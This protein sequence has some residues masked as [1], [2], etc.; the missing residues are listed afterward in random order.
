[1]KFSLFIALMIVSTPALSADGV[2]A[3]SAMSADG[4]TVTATPASRSA[5]A[6]GKPNIP[7]CKMDEHSSVSINVN[8]TGSSIAEVKK[9]I[10]EQT[11]K[12][13]EYA[14]Q[15]KFKKFRLNN[16]NFNIDD[17]NSGSDCLVA[18]KYKGNGNFNYEMGDANE[19]MKFIDFLATQKI[20]AGLSVD[21]NRSGVCRDDD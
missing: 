20:K 8:F 4:V 11:R 12:I 3:V 6:I 21:S 2:A 9:M 13:S 17:D 10:D 7:E 1:M 16:S 18:M 19:A 15:Q 5:M 14:K